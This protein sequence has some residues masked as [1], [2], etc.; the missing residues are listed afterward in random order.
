[1]VKH[2]YGSK[3]LSGFVRRTAEKLNRLG[4][5]SLIEQ[6][7]AEAR[8]HDLRVD[9]FFPRQAS[10]QVPI[11]QSVESA[12]AMNDQPNFY[13]EWE[14]RLAELETARQADQGEGR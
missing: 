2:Q 5:G 4:K 8:A 13:A 12:S 10:A 9:H 7:H 6:L 3:V 14:G 11:F 1:M